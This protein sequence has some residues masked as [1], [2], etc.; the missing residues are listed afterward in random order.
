[1]QRRIFF[2]HFLPDD[3]KDVICLFGISIFLSSLYHE[4]VNSREMKTFLRERKDN[5]VG[6]IDYP[7]R[8]Y[9]ETPYLTP[10]PEINFRWFK[11]ESENKSIIK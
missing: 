11:T 10:H 4:H 6:A 3:S 2:Y 7:L 5:C 8:K 1:M 9:E